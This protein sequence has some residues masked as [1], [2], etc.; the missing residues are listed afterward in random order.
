MSTYTWIIGLPWPVLITLLFLLVGALC[1]DFED[2]PRQ[3]T[4]PGDGSNS[5]DGRPQPWN[6]W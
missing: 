2:A 5:V 4:L 6:R 1:L 3:I